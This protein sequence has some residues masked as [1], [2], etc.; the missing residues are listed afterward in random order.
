MTASAIY[1]GRLSHAR[2]APAPHSFSYRLYM[3]YLDLDELAAGLGSLLLGVE[4]AGPL[5]FRR[6]DYLGDPHRPLKAAVQDEVERALGFRPLGPIRLLTQVR[7]FGYA[8]NPVSFYYCFDGS[9]Q[10][11]QAIVAEI[12]NPPW[13]ERHRYVLRAD[14][15]GA[16]QQLR[17]AFHVSPFFGMDQAYDWR[18]SAPAEVLSVRMSNLEEGK[19]VFQ[20]KLTLSR[21][22]LST[23]ELLRVALRLPLMSW[24]V[25]AAI[26]LHALVLWLK[27]TPFY[28]HPAKE[29]R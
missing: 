14:G 20:A 13:G 17:K 25:Q 2:F 29:N 1:V 11:L 4:R 23:P 5:S 10:V 27:R 19:R 28:Q 18:F 16:R 3:L 15:Q 24:K 8:F 21:R 7:S 6:R 9:G 26:Y 22:P 12:T